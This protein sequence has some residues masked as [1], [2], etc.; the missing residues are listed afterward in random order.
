[1]LLGRKEEKINGNVVVVVCVTLVTCERRLYAFSLV[2]EGVIP[3]AFARMLSNHYPAMPRLYVI[4]YIVEAFSVRIKK[5]VSPYRITSGSNA[6]RRVGPIRSSG[7]PTQLKGSAT[8][9]G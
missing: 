6:L 3:K 8:K 5:A 9:A 7:D 4:S 2:W 1:M